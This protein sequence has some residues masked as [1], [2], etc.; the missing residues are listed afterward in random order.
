MMQPRHGNL[1]SGPCFPLRYTF[2]TVKKISSLSVLILT[3]V[4]FGLGE[5]TSFDRVKVPDASGKQT[6][7]IL[8]FSDNRKSVEVHPVK[9]S[10]VSI[11]Y[12]EIYKCSYEFT[13]KHRVSEGTVAMAPIGIGAV[14]MLTKSKT[15]W[16]EIDYREQ[17]MMKVFVLRMDKHD[18]VHIL[19]AL[20]AHTGIDAEVL[21][22][23]DKRR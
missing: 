8:T 20:K 19:E 10:D 15:H 3:I 4:T 18:Y 7:A 2:K 9:G 22:N 21:G 13:K 14:M 23:A 17:E 1:P 12:A 16:L 6:K 5:E 11:P